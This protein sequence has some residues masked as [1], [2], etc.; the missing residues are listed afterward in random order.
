MVAPG[1]DFADISRK[2]ADIVGEGLVKLGKIRDKSE[3]RKY[4][5]H[6]LSHHLGARVGGRTELGTLE[7][8][9]VFTIEPG[10]YIREEK[11]GVRI[12]DDVLVTKTGHEVLTRHVPKTIAEIEK[13]MKEKGPD[14]SPYLLR[15]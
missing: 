8:G 7:P 4:Y 12:E 13:L 2:A 10:I 5:F 1:V 15:K 14:Y 6:G 11:I 9:M 3:F